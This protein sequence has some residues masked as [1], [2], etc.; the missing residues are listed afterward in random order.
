MRRFSFRLAL[1]LGCTVRELLARVDAHELV[2]WMV[3]YG[4]EPWGDERADLRAGI[5]AAT[6]AN[7]HRTSKGKAFE[8]DD[9]MPKF[10]RE[11]PKQKDP[12]KIAQAM[13]LLASRT[14]GLK[15]TDNGDS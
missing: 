7:C 13:M 12:S 5:Q 8:P 15:R 11:A 6:T 14:G 3:F 2:E 1:A 9:F 4:L 10:D